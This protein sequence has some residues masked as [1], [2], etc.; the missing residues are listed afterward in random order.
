MYLKVSCF[1]SLTY[2]LQE[3]NPT[4]NFRFQWGLYFLPAERVSY[5]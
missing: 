1:I 4:A 5:C 2:F 3:N